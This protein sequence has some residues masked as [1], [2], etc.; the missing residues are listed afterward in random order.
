MERHS[1]KSQ[2]VL[3]HSSANTSVCWWHGARIC[4]T[5][6]AYYISIHDLCQ[7]CTHLYSLAGHSVLLHYMIFVKAFFCSL[8]CLS[9][10]LISYLPS[11]PPSLFSGTIMGM[12]LPSYLPPSLL[13]YLQ[14][15]CSSHLG[16][17]KQNSIFFV[18]AQ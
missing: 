17:G 15:G 5:S 3:I 8:I 4:D 12:I 14:F 6:K 9:F 2:A 1:Q 13:T 10:N 16:K 11:F 18:H 7:H